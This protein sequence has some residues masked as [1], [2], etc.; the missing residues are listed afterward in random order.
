MCCTVW[1]M[2]LEKTKKKG[3]DWCCWYPP[4]STAGGLEYRLLIL[5]ST[6]IF[7]VVVLVQKPEKHRQVAGSFSCSKVYWWLVLLLVL[8]LLLWLCIAWLC[9]CLVSPGSCAY[10]RT[11]LCLHMAL[12]QLLHATRGCCSSPSNS[13]GKNQSLFLPLCPS[14]AQPHTVIFGVFGSQL[15]RSRRRVLFF[16]YQNR[17]SY[18]CYRSKI[19]Q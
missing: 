6:I 9:R 16:F 10:P 8:L 5:F 4:D 1:L 13:R 17:P 15:W 19:V 12:Y 11:V 3:T 18:L 7:L 2:G 14:T